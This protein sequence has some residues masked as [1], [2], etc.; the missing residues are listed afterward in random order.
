MIIGSGL[1]IGIPM[2]IS[3]WLGMIGVGGVVSIGSLA[4]ANLSDE[5][6]SGNNTQHYYMLWWLMRSHSCL[7]HW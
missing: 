3:G 2:I 5:S 1:G 4:I 7:V 6:P